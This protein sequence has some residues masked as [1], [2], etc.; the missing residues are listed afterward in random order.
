M[1]LK[2]LFVTALGALGLGALLAS[3]TASAQQ[4]PA[5]K[6]LGSVANCQGTARTAQG[7]PGRNQNRSPLDIILT[8]GDANDPA[9]TPIARNTADADITADQEAQLLTRLTIDTTA[10]PAT[11]IP[12]QAGI[13]GRL[14]ITT[15]T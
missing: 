7:S 6:V 15:P 5:P 9:A 12:S 8:G 3:G 14:I 13:R 2:R 1:F 10:M 11:P 4:L